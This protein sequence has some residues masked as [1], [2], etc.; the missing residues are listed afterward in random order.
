MIAA[1]ILD[2]HF[3]LAWL[4]AIA[5]LAAGCTSPMAVPDPIKALESPSAGP[6]KH[7]GAMEQLDETGYDQAAIKALSDVVV[8]PGYTAAA[9]EEAFNRLE[10]H[11]PQALQALLKKHL[12][13]IGARAWQEKLCEM[14]AER[15]WVDLG[16]AIAM[17]WAR[18]VGWVAD[19]DRP[20]YH[21]LVKLYG[22]P[23][24]V[25]DALVGLVAQSTNVAVRVRCWSLLYRIGNRARLV[26]LLADTTIA[27]GDVMLI[28]LRAAALELGVIPR[29]YEDI[30]WIE[31]L[32]EPQRHEFWSQAVTALQEIPPERRAELELR[33]LPIV[34]AASLNEPSLLVADKDELYRRVEAELKEARRHIDPRRFEGFPGDYPQRL[35]EQQDKVTWG[36]LAAMILALRAARIPEVAAHLFDFAE[37]DKADKSCEYGGVISLDGRGRFEILE[38]IPRYRGSDE[39]FVAS[40]ELMD[41]AYTAVFQFH[42]HA[43]KY[44][45][46]QHACP[47]IGDLD[48]ADNVA[49]NCLVFTFV[50]RDALNMDYYRHDRFI[51]D[52][53][54]VARPP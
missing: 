38:F 37:R 39:R 53:G 30:L 6:R 5:A 32:R 47:G 36:D 35:A 23:Q 45:N 46:E 22:G 26:E 43:Q 28:D 11:D 24:Q 42:F 14:I 2:R 25:V 4:A 10:A 48:Y 49:A 50:K 34:V 21:A 20:E 51:V 12:A 8:G 9:R 7:L 29:N 18:R 16:P 3:S 33:D 19:F 54:E 15:G 41:A 52:L 17:S 27:P 44:D 13:S 40:Q 1:P 31:K